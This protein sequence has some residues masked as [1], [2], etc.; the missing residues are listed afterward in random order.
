VEVLSDGQLLRLGIGY[1]SSRESITKCG[2]K[3]HISF[4]PGK[5]PNAVHGVL[6][7][8]PVV[9]RGGDG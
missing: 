1:T 4:A 2:K 5:V 6:P 9:G 3:N 8:H 7:E